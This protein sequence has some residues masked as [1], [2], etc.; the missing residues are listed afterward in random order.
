VHRYSMCWY[1]QE[2]S[3]GTKTRICLTLALT[4]A[5]ALALTLALGLEND[6]LE[7]TMTGRAEILTKKQ[8]FSVCKIII[9]T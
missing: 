1:W 9:S 5:L 7:E 6:T 3:L 2:S 8:T 4:L